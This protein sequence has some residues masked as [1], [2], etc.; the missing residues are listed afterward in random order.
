VHQR[1]RSFQNGANRLACALSRSARSE[2]MK[3]ICVA[4]G[5]TGDWRLKHR[6]EALG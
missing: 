1:E 3:M 4:N 2:P 6:Y 5:V